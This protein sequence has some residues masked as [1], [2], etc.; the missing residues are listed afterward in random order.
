MAAG[1]GPQELTP[2]LRGWLLPAADRLDDR[3]RLV[4]QACRLAEEDTAITRAGELAARLGLSPRSLER[5]VRSYVGLSPKWL[6][7]CRRLQQ[8]AT[9]LYGAPDTDL[10]LLAAE[11]G[12]SDYPHFSRQYQ[13]ALGESPR[14]T[15]DG[16]RAALA[17]AAGHGHR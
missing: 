12:Y 1:G 3:G 10:S 5:L 2:V 16:G 11:L 7:E 8:A 17:A 9:T 4:N 15:R 13:Q 14:V 6:I